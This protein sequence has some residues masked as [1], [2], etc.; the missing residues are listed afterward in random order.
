MENKQEQ[1]LLW[2]SANSADPEIPAWKRLDIV[3]RQWATLTG[4]EKDQEKYEILRKMYQ[5]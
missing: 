5:D 3:T 2:Q 1:F 4:F